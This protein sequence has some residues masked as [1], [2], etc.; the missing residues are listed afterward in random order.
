MAK[1]TIHGES[2]ANRVSDLPNREYKT[3][4]SKYLKKESLTSEKNVSNK[5]AEV[6]RKMSGVRH[7]A[8]H[9]FYLGNSFYFSEH[10]FSL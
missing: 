4:N 7:Q 2:W 9:S 1:I 3:Y 10:Q 6:K 8:Y 5:T